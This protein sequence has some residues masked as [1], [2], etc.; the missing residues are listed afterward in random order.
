MLNM[1]DYLSS[2]YYDPKRSGGYGGMERLYA[3]VKKE[4]KFKISREKVKKW[5][6]EQD[7]YTLHKPARRL[8]Q[9]MTTSTIL[10]K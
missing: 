4:G 1:D 8:L 7:A 6:M 10:R 5:L 2:V 9:N 3:D